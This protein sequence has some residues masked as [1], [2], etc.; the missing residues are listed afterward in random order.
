M[1]QSHGVHR[2]PTHIHRRHRRH[3]FDLFESLS[4]TMGGGELQNLYSF[5]PFSANLSCRQNHTRSEQ[6]VCFIDEQ[7][8]M[9]NILGTL[10]CPIDKLKESRKTTGCRD[11]SWDAGSLVANPS[12]EPP[13][14]AV[15][16][17]AAVEL[18]CQPPAELATGCTRALCT[19]PNYC[20]EH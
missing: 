4:G 13:A 17:G 8:N 11:L 3:Y 5:P 6:Y 18:S 12:R 2:G 7:T 19:I 20:A 16:I 14:R 10:A 15:T 1:V 9:V